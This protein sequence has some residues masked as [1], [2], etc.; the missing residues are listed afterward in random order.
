VLAISGH[1]SAIGCMSE[2]GWRLAAPRRIV[3]P[4]IP[5]IDGCTT[6]SP[7]AMPG[8]TVSSSSA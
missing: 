2:I 7:H 1:E 8:S 6:L 3:K 4:W 5:A